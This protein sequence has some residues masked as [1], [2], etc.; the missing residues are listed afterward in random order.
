MT[1]NITKRNVH[2]VKMI[3]LHNDDHSSVAGPNQP[4]KS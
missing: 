2:N 1:I 4:G 3:E